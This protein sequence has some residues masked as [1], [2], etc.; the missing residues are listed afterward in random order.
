MT[1]GWPWIVL[2][3]DPHDQSITAHGPFVREADAWERAQA[4]ADE[5]GDDDVHEHF[6]CVQLVPVTA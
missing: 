1:A 5:S 4:L 6:V 3:E 2:K